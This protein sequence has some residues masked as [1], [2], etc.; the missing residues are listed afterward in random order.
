M[1]RLPRLTRPGIALL[2]L[3]TTGCVPGTVGA[4]P[5]LRYVGGE[6]KSL[7][8]AFIA[9]QGDVQLMLQLY[10]GL[11][12]L[13]E[14]AEVYPSLAQSWSV[15]DD[16]RTYTFTL[17]EGLRFSD[18]TSLEASDVRRSWLRLLDPE[19][20]ATAPDVLGL[21]EGAADRRAG[22]LGEEQVG[23]EAVDASTLV[24]RLRHPAGYFPALLA[25]PATFV[26]PPAADASPDWQT[27][28]GFVGSGPYVVERADGEDL[29]LRA[30]AEYVLGP[31]PIDEVRWIGRLEG[32]A[33]TAFAD[34]E[35][36]LVGVP[37]FDA[38][39]IA[40]DRELGP[41]L[42]PG[43]PANVQF[44]GFDTTR[45][46]FDDPLVR[47]AFALALDRGRLVELSSGVS[48]EPAS[49]IVP[50]AVWPAGWEVDASELAGD[51]GD[52]VELLREAGYKDGSELGTIT[53]NGTGL[54]MSPAIATW[55]EVLGVEF[56]V[57][58][59]DF[60]DYL[61]DLERHT[62]QIFTINWIIDYPSPH[63]LYG[64]L[65]LPGASSN[66]GGWDDAEFVSRLEAAAA[67]LDPD[68]QSAAYAEVEARVDDQAPIIPWAYGAS[69]WLVRDGL[70]GV[71]NL[72][73]G[74]LDLGLVSWDG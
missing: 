61:A 49:S 40:H 52:A 46:P 31:P 20:G 23:I 36:D 18:G 14:Q 45:P 64:L 9:D 8:P 39:W 44:I 13:D 24:V 4:G 35:V 19:V 74:L 48:A 71:G 57:Q 16:G 17:R 43:A 41:S 42:Q 72:T 69:W 6:V 70:R 58:S 34:D 53:V 73:T 27:A 21:V 56:E 63:A 50:P 3:V 30:N 38:A 12:R 67:V 33:A 26:V 65:L 11:T 29:V 51:P 37:W 22:G 68:Q 62:E 1:P 55:R 10:A 32:N 47:R 28:D 5:V 66:Y 2:L 7:D 25:S 60:L 15:S 59:M 54:G